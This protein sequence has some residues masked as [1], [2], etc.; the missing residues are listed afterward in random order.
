MVMLAEDEYDGY[1]P[2]DYERWNWD[3]DFYDAMRHVEEVAL[4]HIMSKCPVCG[5]NCGE[6]EYMEGDP[7]VGIF[8]GQ[9]DNVCW[10]HGEF[11][12][13]DDGNGVVRLYDEL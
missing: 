10:E 1:T 13:I 3:W 6:P 12:L 8:Y 2:E 9:Y 4:F 7:S 5:A 11:F